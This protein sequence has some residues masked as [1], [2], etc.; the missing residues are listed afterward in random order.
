MASGKLIPPT[1]FTA[2]SNKLRARYLEQLA[3]MTLRQ[4][5]AASRAVR[6]QAA[7]PSTGIRRV[8][9]PIRSG[10]RRP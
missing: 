2:H 4:T 8:I 3:S 5:A 6:A 10:V 7:A 9:F 1:T